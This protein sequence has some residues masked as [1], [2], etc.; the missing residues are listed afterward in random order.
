MFEL[1]L[2]HEGEFSST[3]LAQH[4]ATGVRLLMRSFDKELVFANA[5]AYGRL[6][7]EHDARA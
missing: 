3:Y 2:V 7:H 1:S 5:T 6:C 4:T